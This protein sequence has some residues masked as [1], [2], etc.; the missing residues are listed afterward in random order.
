MATFTWYAYN[1]AGSTVTVG[2]STFVFSGSATDL[3][4]PV[5]VAAWQDGTHIGTGDP[6]TDQ[7]GGNHIH[8]TKWTSSTQYS[9]DGAGQETLNDTTLV[10]TECPIYILFNESPAVSTSNARFYAFNS[11]TATTRAT[12]VDVYAYER[13]VGYGSGWTLIND[14]SGGTGGDNSGQ[15]LGLSDQGSATN[16][17]FYLA[18]TVSPESVGGKSDFDLGIAL[19]YS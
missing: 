13:G 7:C 5:T 19:T 10:T 18:I 9:L 14:S 11:T 2:S 15:R 16:H 8:N 4:V 6:G 17:S 3:T 12:G 1:T